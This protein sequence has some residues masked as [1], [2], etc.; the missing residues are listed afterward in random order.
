MAELTD[1]YCIID[2]SEHR[3]KVAH[4]MGAD[5]TVHVD[6]TDSQAL[7]EKVKSTLGCQPDITIECSGAESSIQTGIYVSTFGNQ[8][9]TMSSKGSLKLCAFHFEMNS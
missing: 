4:E 9:K 7:A 5:Y 6:T 8:A 1:L 2:I 3:L